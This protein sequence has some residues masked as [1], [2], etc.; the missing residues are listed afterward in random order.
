[1]IRTKL[2]KIALGL[3]FTAWSPLL[4]VGLVSKNLSK[5]FISWDAYGVL[6]LSRLIT[7]IKYEVHGT[8]VKN[9]IIASKHMSILEIAILK[10]KVYPESF[11]IIKQELMMIPI[12]GWAFW[13]I[14]Y[15]GVNRKPGATNMKVL[16]DKVAKKIQ[17]GETLVIFPEGTRAKPGD[18]VHLRRGLLLIA[19]TAKIQIQP[20]GTDAG[21]YWPKHGLMH[22]GTAHVWLEP[23]LPYNASLDEI[24]DAIARHSA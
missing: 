9:S 6:W 3:W 8:P 16:A 14:G 15:I 10:L 2:F 13:R 19:Q 1:M 23:V 22:S 17:N 11:F 7:G 20:V 5:K 21:L 18:G 24:T 4:L 12:Y